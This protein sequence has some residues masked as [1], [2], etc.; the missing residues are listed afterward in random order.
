MGRQ[1]HVSDDLTTMTMSDLLSRYAQFSELCGV[2]VNR[3]SASEYAS[4]TRR[5]IDRRLTEAIEAGGSE[6]RYAL[7]GAS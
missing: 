4:A 6:V 7:E 3:R 1:D 5:E 2:G